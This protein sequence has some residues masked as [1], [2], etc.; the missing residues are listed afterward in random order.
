MKK[1]IA[2]QNNINYY[3]E[4]SAIAEGLYTLTKEYENIATLT[5]ALLKPY[6]YCINELLKEDIKIC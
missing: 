2:S 4:E 5:L 6:N 3:L 1:L